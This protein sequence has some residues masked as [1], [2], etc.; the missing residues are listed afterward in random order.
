MIGLWIILCHLVGDYIL[1][2]DWMVREKTKSWFP[3]FMHGVFYTIPY[4]IFLGVVTA[5]Y[6]WLDIPI[7]KTLVAL[8][9]IA[10]THMVID[11]YRLVKY[12]IWVINQ[13]NPPTEWYSLKAAKANNGYNTDKPVWMSTWLMIIVDNTLH[14]VINTLAV[15]FVIGLV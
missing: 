12:L 4:A 2:N 15:M 6:T 9:I 5:S 14:L 13:I 7:W 3:A 10:G 8:G 1:Q 11:R